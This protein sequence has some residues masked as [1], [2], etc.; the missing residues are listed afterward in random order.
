MKTR[1]MTAACALAICFWAA[2]SFG[3]QGGNM[4][5]D[6]V[7]VRPVCFL[8]TVVGSALFVVSLPVSAISKSVRPAAHALVV[9]PAKVTFTR[10]LGDFKP[11]EDNWDE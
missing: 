9:R 11:I 5:V 4:A 10:P 1:L 6:A 3:D 7:I 2:P 8:A